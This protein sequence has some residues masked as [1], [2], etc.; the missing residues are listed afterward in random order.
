MQ[1]TIW[2]AVAG[3][4]YQM[5]QLDVIANNL[6]NA[7]TNGFKADHMSFDAYLA[8]IQERRFTGPRERLSSIHKQMRMH[9]DH[10]QGVL[11]TTSNSLDLAIGG[12]G[13]F[14]IET[15]DGSMYTR[16]GNFTLN[17]QGQVVTTEGNLV[18][19]ES[20]AL[21]LQTG[22]AA[23]LV[24][25]E[26][27]MLYQA[28]EEV[29]RLQ[30]TRVDNPET[31]QKAGGKLFRAT[32]DTRTEVMET[33]DVHQGVLEGSNVNMVKEVVGIVQAGRSFEAY[34]RMISL[35][36]DINRRATQQLGQMPS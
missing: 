5:K 2:N 23:D 9:T 21:Q 20:G 13:F 29:G 31:L 11:K 8:Q 12:E 18:L 25:N 16:A 36:D 15:P 14:T 1:N 10:S 7:N 17:E 6:A 24:F 34:Q 19:G 28:G 35:V 30:I 32:Q 3:S 33:P 22:I 26:Q 27:G 4:L